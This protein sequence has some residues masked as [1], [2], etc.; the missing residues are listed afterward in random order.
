MIGADSN[1]PGTQFTGMDAASDPG[2]TGGIDA[3]ASS[4]SD[5][6]YNPFAGFDRYA[7]EPNVGTAYLG[8]DTP[9]YGSSGMNARNAINALID[10]QA[11]PYVPGPAS[12]NID[13]LRGIPSWAMLSEDPRYGFRG[14]EAPAIPDRSPNYAYGMEDYPVDRVVTRPDFA[15]ATQP[16]ATQPTEPGLTTPVYGRSGMNERE[17]VRSLVG[18]GYG[19]LE[20][21]NP[22]NP[23]QT[24]QQLLNSF[25]A[26]DFLTEY[27]PSLF[28]A[29]LPPGMAFAFNALRSGADIAAGRTTPGQALMGVGLEA[30]ARAAGLPG[31]GPIFGDLLEGRV[32]SAA[33]RAASGLATGALGRAGLG[34]FAPIFA[35]EAGI[36][37]AISKSVSDA[38][39]PQAGQGTGIVSAL[40]KAFDRGFQD[41]TGVFGGTPSAPIPA[42]PGVTTPTRAY[43]SPDSNLYESGG[44]EPSAAATAPTTPAATTPEV[45]AARRLLYGTA[46]G[47]YGPLLAYDFG[48]A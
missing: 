16:T 41:L 25:R 13:S 17:A 5:S 21:L 29:G 3:P 19:D 22:N 31:G 48:E 35:K 1:D 34:A 18:M 7:D 8:L 24:A 9:V 4:Y 14:V 40:T 37:P 11:Y 23:D 26:N 20:G 32:G 12:P 42:T 30:V 28:T 44:P 43:V 46:Q 2:T 27:A 33:G 39:Q 15:P 38:V 10:M 47:P 45:T 36:T 6:N